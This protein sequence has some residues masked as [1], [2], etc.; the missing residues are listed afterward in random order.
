[1]SLR[2]SAQAFM[3]FASLKGGSNR[4]ITD[5]H[6]VCEFPEVFSDD[7]NDLP[8]EHEVEFAIT[9]YLV[10]VLCRWLLIGCLL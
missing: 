3:V 6:V 2:E 10:L 1:M 4:I 5:L 8:S 7:I 9:Q